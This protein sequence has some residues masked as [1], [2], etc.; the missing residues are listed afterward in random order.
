MPRSRLTSS[1]N[2]RLPVAGKKRQNQQLWSFHCTKAVAVTETELWPSR[3][4]EPRISDRQTSARTARRLGGWR[5]CGELPGEMV[6]CKSIV[7]SRSGPAGP[8]RP[9][10]A[11]HGR[12]LLKG[13][14]PVYHL[15]WALQEPRSKL[16]HR[17]RLRSLAED[18]ARYV[19]TTPKSS[20]SVC[21]EWKSHVCRRTALEIPSLH[22]GGSWKC[23]VLIAR[24]LGFLCHV[25]F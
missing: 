1:P 8:P 2:Q 15:S 25:L 10:T 21:S 24:A 19:E 4:T 3:H 9:L 11:P 16:K 17:H 7:P 22:G 14:R 13:L 12:Q 18:L 20:E 6:S 5:P 23:G